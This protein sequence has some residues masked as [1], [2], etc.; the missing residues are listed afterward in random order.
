VNDDRFKIISQGPRSGIG[1]KHF[2]ELDVPLGK[3]LLGRFS[4][5]EIYSDFGKRRG[6][7][8]SFVQPC[9]APVDCHLRTAA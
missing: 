7:D 8:V 1:A 3:A 9:H 4:D 2:K 5:G 6:A